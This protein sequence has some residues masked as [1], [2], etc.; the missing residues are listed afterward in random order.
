MLRRRLAARDILGAGEKLHFLARRDVQHMHLRARLAREADE[1]LG[2]TQSRDLV[3]PDRMGGGVAS[4]AQ[5]LALIQA[6][7]VFAVEGGAAADRL[8]DR[9]HPFVVGDQEAPGRGAHEHLDPRRARQP[10]E[11]G[12][13]GDIVV[14][15]PTQKAKSQCIRPFARLSLSASASALI[16]RGSV[17][18]ISNTA[19]TPPKNAPREPV[20]R[21]SL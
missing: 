9:E 3:A 21:S 16:V 14:R 6:R 8:Q 5:S 12:N 20:S 2:R 1:A 19:V 17:L 11:L 10:L 13:F 7:L 4:D 18:G 15:A